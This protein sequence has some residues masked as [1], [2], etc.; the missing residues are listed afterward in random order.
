VTKFELWAYLEVGVL[1]LTAEAG[2]I[3][4]PVSSRIEIDQNSN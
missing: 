3:H 1:V 4:F 2:L